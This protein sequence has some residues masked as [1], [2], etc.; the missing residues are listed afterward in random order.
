MDAGVRRPPGGGTSQDEAAVDQGRVSAGIDGQEEAGGCPAGRGAEQLRVG[1]GQLR[2]GLQ[3]SA[4][5]WVLCDEWGCR[6]GL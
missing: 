3:A 4:R 1:Q 5:V 6:R 2:P